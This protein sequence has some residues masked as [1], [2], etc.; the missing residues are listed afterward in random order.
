MLPSKT[1]TS[2]AHDTLLLD[3]IGRHNCMSTIKDLSGFYH[4]P[5]CKIALLSRR[6]LT[7]T[8]IPKDILIYIM[9]RQE[10][11]NRGQQ[12]TL[13]L[14]FNCF[15]IDRNFKIIGITLLSTNQITGH[16]EPLIAYPHPGDNS[17]MATKQPQAVL[18]KTKM[19]RVLHKQ[20]FKIS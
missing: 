20:I 6:E 12:L 15:L 8:L 14:K 2:I 1:I 10:K 16:V 13:K 9:L 7:L 4:S 3:N 17:T 18:L 19:P 5:L 11:Q